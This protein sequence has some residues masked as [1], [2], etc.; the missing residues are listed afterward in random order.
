MLYKIRNIA[1][2]WFTYWMEKKRKYNGIFI[3]SVNIRSRPSEICRVHPPPP[4]KHFP[5]GNISSYQPRFTLLLVQGRVT[6]QIRRTEEVCDSMWIDHQ[7]GNKG[8]KAR[9]G[10]ET[11]ILKRNFYFTNLY[12]IK[13]MLSEPKPEDEILLFINMVSLQNMTCFV[14]TTGLL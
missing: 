6:A 11:R 9:T 3:W 2:C 7:R 12:K 4:L 13:E 1:W 5:W 10:S 8:N 14:V